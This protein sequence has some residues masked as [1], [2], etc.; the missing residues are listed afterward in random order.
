MYTFSPNRVS[1]EYLFFS[2]DIFSSNVI[3]NS[4]ALCC[5]ITAELGL[6]SAAPAPAN[7]YCVH[8]YISTST[9]PSLTSPVNTKYK[10]LSDE[11]REEHLVLNM[12]GI[13]AQL[14]RSARE[15]SNKVF[16]FLSS[17]TTLS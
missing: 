17:V 14:T 10:I 11:V 13:I 6:L 12:A 8:F 3:T 2:V 9:I 16:K 4:E 7:G 5:E 15:R 1:I